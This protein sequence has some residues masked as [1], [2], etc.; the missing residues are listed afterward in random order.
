MS[1]FMPC[2]GAYLRLRI[3]QIDS[4]IQESI[5]TSKLQVIFVGCLDCQPN[6]LGTAIRMPGG[7]GGVLSDGC[8]CLNGTRQHVHRIL[9]EIVKKKIR[10]PILVATPPRFLQSAEVIG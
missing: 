10:P 7:V 6:R 5:L 3:G 2:K 9:I 1:A 8:P 4:V